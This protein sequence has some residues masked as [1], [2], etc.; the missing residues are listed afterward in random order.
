M[1]PGEYKS[2]IG[3]EVVL[4]A[5]GKLAMKNSNGLLAGATKSLLENIEFLIS[6]NLVPLDKAW[7]MGSINPAKFLGWQSFGLSL[8]Q[9]ADMVEFHLS[10][11][12]KIQI[13]RVI[14]DGEVV[15]GKK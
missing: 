10:E 13:D 3:D 15:F 12:K 14:K 11:G 9:P 6:Q 4:S 8:G 1:E 7:K 5:E 2:H